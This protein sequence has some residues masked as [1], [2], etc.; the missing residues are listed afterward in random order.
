MFQNNPC[1]SKPDVSR[2]T[3][4]LAE[5]YRHL[6]GSTDIMVG[7]EQVGLKLYVFTPY[8]PN[9]DK[10]LQFSHIQYSTRRIKITI[11]FLIVVSVGECVSKTVR[12]YDHT[13]QVDG[14]QCTSESGW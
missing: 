1:K 3:K 7:Y 6:A 5:M 9:S 2:T 10:F 8:C 4:S 14:H 12:F 11:R 13:P